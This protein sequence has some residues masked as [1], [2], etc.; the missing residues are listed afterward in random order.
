ML[1]LVFIGFYFAK[2]AGNDL[3]ERLLGMVQGRGAGDGGGGAAGHHW[4]EAA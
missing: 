2:C 1:N 4:L 3:R